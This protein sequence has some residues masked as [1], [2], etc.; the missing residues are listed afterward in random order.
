MM[1]HTTRTIKFLQL[2]NLSFCA[3]LLSSCNQKKHE[4][5]DPVN[6]IIIYPDQMRGQAMGFLQQEP[7]Q[8]PHLDNF[9][10]QSLVL[11]DAISNYPVCSPTRAS[12]MTG[13]YPMEHGVLSNC[14]S[15]SAPFGYELKENATTWSDVL[16][17]KGYSLGYIGKWHLDNPYEPYI[18][19]I[20]NRT[21]IKWNEWCPPTRR[22]GF[23]FWYAYGTYDDH[24]RPMYWSTSAT[25]NSFKYIDQWGPEH[26]ADQAISYLKNENKKYRD[27]N[28]PFALMV[29]MNPPHT[30]YER[31]PDKYKDIYADIPIETLAH[32]GNIPPIGTKWGDYYRAN[33]KNYYAMI[34]GVD[35][36][37]GR[38]MKALKE[39]GLEENTIVLFS[40]DHGNCLG[41]HDNF[42][43]NVHYEESVRVPFLIRWP[44]KI[45]K[46]FD[47][48]LLSTP[49]IYP[50]LLGLMGFENAIPNDV[51]GADHSSLFLTGKG[52]R[53][54][55]Q[56]YMHIPVGKPSAGRRG[57]RTNQYTL[58]VNKTTEATDEIELF[59]NQADPYQLNNL[60]SSRKDL[61]KTLRNEMN[62]WLEKTNDPWIEN[63][64]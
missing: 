57:V 51:T 46:G 6:L 39:E 41:I 28:E 4:V 40:S 38:I 50:T 17:D 64:K 23:D 63:Y 31:V 42:S 54:N 60:S 61:V 37:F 56:L 62:L 5:S 44:D 7:V 58:M 26:E 32:R 16:K 27:P 29:S 22:H 10:S 8:T 45:K 13:K 15:Q 1:Q 14:N 25:R 33:I 24:T 30:P 11:T 55:S 9:A 12:L 34:S 48:L 43:K 19:C 35:D 21:P 52:Q 36:Q 53:P 18:D 47:D 49:D 3:L 20:N 2:I 59:D